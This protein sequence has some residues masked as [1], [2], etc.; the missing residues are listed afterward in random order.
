MF[1]TEHVLQHRLS[2][3][4]IFLLVALWRT[5]GRIKKPV[6]FGD[7]TPS[8]MQ[9][10]FIRS[11]W[12]ATPQLLS[13]IIGKVRQTRK[14]VLFGPGEMACVF[15][16]TDHWSRFYRIQVKR[17]TSR[18]PDAFKII[19]KQNINFWACPS[20]TQCYC[21]KYEL[22]KLMHGLL[23]VMLVE[24]RDGCPN[25]LNPGTDNIHVMWCHPL[26]Q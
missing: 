16:I 15:S 2:R 9:R 26:Y 22:Q 3:V 7:T 13:Q 8:Q 11:S 6:L 24:V 10:D 12:I 5:Q 25:L 20:R 18:R 19:H 1:W 4:N 21:S 14:V 23:G 17:T